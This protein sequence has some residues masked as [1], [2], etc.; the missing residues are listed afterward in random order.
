MAKRRVN[1][2]IGFSIPLGQTVSNILTAEDLAG[3]GALSI[4][5]TPTRLPGPRA[6]IVASL[7]LVLWAVPCCTV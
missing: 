3:V 7:I 2:P 1:Y 5:A 4:A 6:T